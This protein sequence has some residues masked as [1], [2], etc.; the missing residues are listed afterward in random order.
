MLVIV[1]RPHTQS[2][3]ERG[4]HGAFSLL[5]EVGGL[6]SLTPDARSLRAY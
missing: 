2:F 4:F 1:I 3:E 6:Q 5:D